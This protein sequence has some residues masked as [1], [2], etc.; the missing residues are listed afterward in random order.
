MNRLTSIDL[1][2]MSAESRI[3]YL[4]DL[5]FDAVDIIKDISNNEYNQP[6]L[7]DFIDHAAQASLDIQ[8]LIKKG[9]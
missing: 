7:K 3:L 6:Y 5:L 8:Q 2:K 4:Q 9:I 1:T